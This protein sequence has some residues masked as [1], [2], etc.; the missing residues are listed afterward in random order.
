M[1]QKEF[2]TLIATALQQENPTVTIR[3]GAGADVPTDL[4]NGLKGAEL[5][6]VTVDSEQSNQI[7]LIKTLVPLLIPAG[8]AQEV[9]FE[10]QDGVC[11]DR[12]LITPIVGGPNAKVLIEYQLESLS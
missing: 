8:T 6:S 1:L 9:V 7:F 4:D 2:R 12:M 10:N 5:A 11:I 3:V